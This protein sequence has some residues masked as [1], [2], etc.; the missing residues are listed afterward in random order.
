MIGRLP[1]AVVVAVSYFAG[2]IPFTNIAAR[3]LRGVD[4]RQVGSGTVSGTGLHA[5]AGFGPLAVV[6]CIEVAKGALGPLLAG[7]DRP[8]LAAASAGAAIA[9][10]N[11][12][13]FLGFAGGRGIAPALGATVAVAP[14]GTVALSAGMV[15]GRWGGE[16]A[17]GSLVSILALPLVMSRPGRPAG[18]ATGIAIAVPMI[19]KRLAGNGPWS[20]PSRR[21]AYVNRFLLDRDTRFSV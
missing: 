12:S 7:R 15:L 16:T 17:V 21:S 6:G 14:E 20:G 13:P 8:K 5:V 9:G 3:R 1:G 4:L 10:H 18:C 2:A 19:V 11:W